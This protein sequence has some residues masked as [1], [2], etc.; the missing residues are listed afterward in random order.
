MDV[1][2]RRW[3]TAA[4]AS[5]IVICGLFVATPQPAGAAGRGSYYRVFGYPDGQQGL[6]VE[7]YLCGPEN[8]APKQRV[9]P[10]PWPFR[11]VSGSPDPYGPHGI[12]WVPP[13]SGEALG[14]ETYFASPTDV[15]VFRILLDAPAGNTAGFAQVWYFP[16]GSDVQWQGIARFAF[17]QN[18]WKWT[19]AASAGFDWY[20]YTNGVYDGTSVGG[21]TV[22]GFTQSQGGDG[23]G[24]YFSFLLGCDGNPFSVDGFEIGSTVSGW[25]EFDFEGNKT[26]IRLHAT[27]SVSTCQTSPARWPNKMSFRG[28]LAP[29]GRWLGWKFAPARKGKW[30]IVARG[31]T[32][33]SFGY[34]A[35]VTENAFFDA[36]YPPT[37][38]SE[39]SDTDNIYV[40]AFPS[41]SLRA[42]DRAVRKGHRIVF[43][44]T[45]KP[46]RRLTY[47]PL[48]AVAG[49][50]GWTRFQ[51][52]GTRKTDNRGRF[53]FV[54]PTPSVGWARINILT[55]TENGL[56][57]T[58]NPRAVLYEVLK[59]KKKPGTSPPPNHPCPTHR[60]Q[61]RLPRRIR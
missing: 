38:T 46:A 56:T 60:T 49:K 44:G 30:R 23:E 40:P 6:T 15:N 1:T 48:R 45:I 2:T 10:S 61:P 35:K 11:I 12:G 50:R 5:L 9:D 8:R 39:Y 42:S 41:I 26:R 3:R 33:G 27:R 32:Q 16:P 17:T 51:S 43:T 53:R 24:A 18:D 22:P 55:K 19:N 36:D 25:D 7:H 34:T 28:S 13:S 21:Q 29:A 58:I 57:S 4:F 47:T 20:R 14:V 31:T 37:A 54:V 52:L 59:P